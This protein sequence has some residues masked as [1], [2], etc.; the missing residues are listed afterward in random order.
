MRRLVWVCLA[1]L[2]A[3]TAACGTNNGDDIGDDDIGDVGFITADWNFKDLANDQIVTE[4]PPGFDTAAVNSNSVDGG[5]DFVDLYDCGALTGTP[6]EGYPIDVYSVFVSIEDTNGTNVFATSLAADVD[7]TAQDATY[8]TTILLDGGYFAATWNLVDAAT[9]DPLDCAGA[10]NPEA[11]EIRSTTAGTMDLVVDQF[12]CEDGSGI[13][14]G[15]LAGDYTVS[16]AA[17]SGGADL[18]EP[19]VID[20]S[21]AP[22][23][24]VTDLGT[25]TLPID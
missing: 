8:Q 10:G 19:A 14:A 5:E 3:T 13:T 16:L 17:Q 21:I 25:V 4:C 12:T 22:Q 11:I 1:A 23:N 20:S 24:E 15:L 2:A 9:N 7:L 6:D 18:G